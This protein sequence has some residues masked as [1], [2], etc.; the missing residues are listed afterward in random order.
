MASLDKKPDSS[1]NGLAELQPISTERLLLRPF[2]ESDALRVEMLLDD[3]EIASNT[4]RIDY[5]YPKGGGA[6]WIATHQPARQ[7]GDGYVFAICCWRPQDSDSETKDETG[8][9]EPCLIG[10]IGLEI[11]KEDH[12]AELGYWIGRHFWNQG[13]CTEATKAVIEFGFETLGLRRIASQHMARN[14]A[15]GRV[16]E[17][18]GMTR[19]GLLR[20]H[21][22]KWGV[23]EDVVVYGILSGD[24]RP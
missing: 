5:P 2:T 3:K 6:D 19:E 10:A 7:T 17:K 4:K 23:F 20:K 24:G 8:D 14:P 21:T 9:D 1:S 12:N 22:R 13:Y 15:S 11:N 18:A 16:M